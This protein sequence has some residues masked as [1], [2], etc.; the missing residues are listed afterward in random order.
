MNFLITT[1]L[2]LFLNLFL[3]VSFCDTPE[4]YQFYIQDPA[5]DV[6]EWM[7]SFHDLLM[8]NMILIVGI[9]FYLLY[10]LLYDSDHHKNSNKFFSHSTNLEIFWTV[11]PAVILLTIAYPSFN[12]LYALDDFTDPELTIKII[13]HQWYWSYEYSNTSNS[14]NKLIQFD[15]YMVATD[16]LLPGMIRLLEV[17]NRLYIPT[18]KHIR[19]LITA[20]DVLHS[21]AVPSFGIKVD[22]CPG[23]LNQATLFVKRPGIYF[24]QCSEI[25]GINHG[26]M[27]IVVRAIDSDNFG[28]LNGKFSI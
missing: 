26:F 27:P 5:T 14:G 23:R 24:G 21:W 3:F 1:S 18:N 22:A 10:N 7:I 12:L 6:L 8:V 28:N 13:G 4:P 25:C 16:D 20:S 17:D 11:I 15:S 2:N 19:L 9:I